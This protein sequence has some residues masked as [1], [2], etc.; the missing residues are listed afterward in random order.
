M[1]NKYENYFLI[2][3]LFAVISFEL[4]F[5]YT[6]PISWLFKPLTF[7]FGGL[8]LITLMAAIVKNRM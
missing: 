5:F 2:F 6:I 4:G 8:F 7:I 3:L 1:E